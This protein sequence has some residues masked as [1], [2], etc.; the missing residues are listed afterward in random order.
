MKPMVFRAPPRMLART[1][2]R[3]LRSHNV[4]G[5]CTR[6]RCVQYAVSFNPEL[7]LHGH[8]SATTSSFAAPYIHVIARE[9]LGPRPLP[10]ICQP[11]P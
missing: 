8:L 4:H 5:L 9:A 7:G 11:T 1:T 10:L 2:R 3:Y 6:F